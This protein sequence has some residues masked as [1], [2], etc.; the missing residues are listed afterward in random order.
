MGC[1]AAFAPAA[2]S[3]TVRPPLTCASRKKGNGA[4][5]AKLNDENDPFLQAAINRASLRFQETQ[6][7]EP[8][9]LDPYVGSF[10][11]PDTLMDMKQYPLISA[12]LHPYCLATKFIDDKLLSTMNHMDGGPR[13]GLPNHHPYSLRL[14]QRL[15]NTLVFLS[16]QIAPGRRFHAT[17]LEA[18]NSEAAQLVVLLTDGMDTRPYRLSWPN[19]SIIFDISPERVF[20]RAAQNLEGVGAK[21][22]R[23]CFF[24]HVP[25]ES[26]SIQEI[27]QR[28]GFSGN[29]PSIWA[30]QGLPVMTLES[31]KEILFIVS[32]LAMKECFFLG[33]LPAWLAETEIGFKSSAERWM[34]KLFMSNGF[35]VDIMDYDEVA[36]NVG[37]DPPS[38]DCGNKLFVA[39]Q[40]R[41]SDDQWLLVPPTIPQHVLLGCGSEHPENVRGRNMA[42]KLSSELVDAAKGTNAQMENW[43][44]EF[45]RLEEEGDEEG[46]DEL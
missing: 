29:R 15:S 28:K 26:S 4:L 17:Q 13:Q 38:E 2:A 5:R 10:V 18:S 14:R 27:L 40:L 41:L 8:L 43:R 6:R 16:S 1:F 23:S 22:P 19:S 24:L 31:F 12:S 3:A 32:S 21:I 25:L 39:E 42:F 20:K 30:F 9:F 34:D 11:T 35:R 33:E 45:Q 36:R 37:K 46:F 44:T 7:P